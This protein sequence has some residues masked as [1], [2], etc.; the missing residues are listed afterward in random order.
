MV[1]SRL[2]GVAAIIG[3][4]ASLSLGRA[5]VPKDAGG[6]QPAPEV[7]VI[8]VYEGTYPPGVR[9]RAGFHPNGAVT[10][11]VGEVKTPVILVLTSYEPVV[12]KVAA[13]KGA[14]V[15]VIASGYHKQTV[16]G[17]DEKVPVTLLSHEAGDKAY[18]YAR[19]KEA[20]P[21]ESDH[22]QAETK[23]KWDRLVERV[24]ELTKQDV[25]EFQGKYAG[26]SFEVK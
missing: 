24:K 26:E 19:R 20:G 4:A 1:L 12:W 18:F 8:G 16:E 13:P 22:E 5:P 10:V 15:R 6:N 7:R 9:H 14:V 17:L 3:F 2:L 25:K 11:K 23:R 21:N